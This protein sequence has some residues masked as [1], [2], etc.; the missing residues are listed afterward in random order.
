MSEITIFCPNVVRFESNESDLTLNNDFKDHRKVRGSCN[1]GMAG[2]QHSLHIW[3]EDV[4]VWKKVVGAV[5]EERSSSCAA[6]SI[7]Y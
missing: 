4:N 2:G 3:S 7:L 6:N 5:S 1:R